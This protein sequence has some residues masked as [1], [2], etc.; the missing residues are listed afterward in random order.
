METIDRISQ[1]E[2]RCTPAALDLLQ[3]LQRHPCF[4][5]L[6]DNLDTMDGKISLVDVQLAFMELT[7]EP[8][9]HV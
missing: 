9:H 7:T 8:V 4:P 2:T 3:Y 6:V 5:D 1:L